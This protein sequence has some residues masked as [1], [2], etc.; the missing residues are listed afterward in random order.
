MTFRDIDSWGDWCLT[1]ILIVVPVCF[2]VAVGYVAVHFIR[3][4]W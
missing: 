3:K 1:V 2:L 4:W